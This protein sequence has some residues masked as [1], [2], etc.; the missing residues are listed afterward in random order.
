M[1][2]NYIR[3]FNKIVEI[4]TTDILFEC[5][6]GRTV[7]LKKKFDNKNQWKITQDGVFVLASLI[8]AYNLST[9][10]VYV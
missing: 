8:K 6:D 3:V 2:D 1:K 9:S 10:P 5:I 4:C 7:F